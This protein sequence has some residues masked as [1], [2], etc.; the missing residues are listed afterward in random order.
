MINH[1]CE[2]CTGVFFGVSLF[3]KH[4]NVFP[5]IQVKTNDKVDVGP[6]YTGALF[7]PVL[8]LRLLCTIELQ[9]RSKRK[10]K[11]ENNK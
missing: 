10:K 8:K 7:T 11:T 4:S 3:S 5:R 6:N 1:W 2:D 9:N